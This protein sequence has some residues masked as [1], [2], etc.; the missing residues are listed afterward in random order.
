MAVAGIAML[1]G[2]SS[3]DGGNTP[4]QDTPA[5]SDPI[6]A[7]WTPEKIVPV[8]PVIGEVDEYAQNYPHQQGC[9]KDYVD[10]Q[11][12]H[13]M[14]IYQHN[15]DCTVNEQTETWQKNNTTITINVLGTEIEGTIISPAEGNQLIIESE[16][17]E[18][19]SIIEQYYPGIPIPEGTKIRLYLNKM[20]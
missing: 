20:S 11:P 9:D 16:A 18:Y 6:V 8:V 12:Q 17:Q 1:A 10:L 2:C 3:D 13:V 14:K 7:K 15:A 4:G 5:P 19:Q